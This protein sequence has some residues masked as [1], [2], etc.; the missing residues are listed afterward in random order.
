MHEIRLDL[1]DRGAFDVILGEVL[2]DG[3]EGWVRSITELEHFCAKIYRRPDALP[4]LEQRLDILSG[5][6]NG[7]WHVEDG[8]PELA[9]PIGLC[10]DAD[11]TCIGFAMQKLAWPPYAPLNDVLQPAAAARR[12]GFLTWEH[13]VHFAADIA[14]IVGKLHGYDVVVGDLC[15]DNIFVSLTDGRTT[16]VD[17]DSFQLRGPDGTAHPTYV[18]RSD[19][20]APELLG[21][22]ST[23]WRSHLSDL[24]PLG[25]VIAQILLDR[26]HPFAGYPRTESPPDGDDL[27]AYCIAAGLSWITEPELVDPPRK[28]PDASAILS[29]GLIELMHRC[30]SLGAEAP[31]KRPLPHEWVTELSRLAAGLK[32]CSINAYHRFRG[33]LTHCPWCLRSTVIGRDP[34]P[35]PS[36]PRPEFVSWLVDTDDTADREAA[37]LER[38]WTEIEEIHA[39]DGVVSGQVVDVTKGGLIVD[40]GLRAFLPV[41]QIEI[42]KPRPR[43]EYVGL[44]IEA[45][46]TKL[47]KENGRVSLSRRAWL[48][49]CEADIRRDLLQKLKRI[50]LCAGVVSRVVDFGAIVDLGGI[51]GLVHKSELAWTYVEDPNDVVKAG[52]QITVKVLNVDFERERVSLSLKAAV[53]DPWQRFVQTRKF[54]EIVRMRV[55]KIV[56]FGAFVRSDDDVEGLVHISELADRFVVNADEVVDVDEVVFVKLIKIEHDRK[57]LSFSLK[58]ADKDVTDA[59]DDFDPDLYGMHEYDEGGNYIYPSGF[60][61]DLQEWLTGFEHQ[62]DAWEAKYEQSHALWEAHREFVR[63]RTRTK[64][65]DLPVGHEGA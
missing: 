7:H 12:N 25:I 64:G 29:K 61:V 14:R 51:E 36:T 24:T 10:R 2:S 40:V 26:V 15:I 27:D 52:Q 42:R 57:R 4:L 6:G 30:F 55:V 43:K 48:E 63:Q 5:F 33:G 28:A 32:T 23:A 53:E 18:M 20:S 39:S 44:H 59:D 38:I 11:G 37:E 56:P 60:S 45:K 8:G 1:G 34:F 49:Q 46:I 65:A 16:L 41:Q 47:D 19:Y 21:R 13:C 31:E 9:Y 35:Q 50:E 22:P 62:R 3:G 54:G 17:V 58:Q